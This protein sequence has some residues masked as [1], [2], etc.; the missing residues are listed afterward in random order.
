MSR[1]KRAFIEM[2]MGW[3][4][5]MSYYRESNRER[6]VRTGYPNVREREERTGYPSVT[7][8]E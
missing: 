6:E 4:Y 5:A 8:R 1:R 7:E 3:Q 2:T